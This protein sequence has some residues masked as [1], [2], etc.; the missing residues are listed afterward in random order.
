M[1]PNNDYESWRQ[2]RRST[3]VP[4][5]FAD[6]VMAAIEQ[7]QQRVRMGILRRL[8]LSTF[9][10]RAAKATVCIV[11]AVVCVARVIHVF[12]IFYVQ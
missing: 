3:D 9:A 11:A 8:I 4:S 1:T 2:L 5:G 10:R 6:G 7:S 12:A